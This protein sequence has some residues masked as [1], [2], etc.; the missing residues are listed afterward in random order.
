MVGQGS[1]TMQARGNEEVEDEK[2]GGREAGK[3]REPPADGEEDEGDFLLVAVPGIPRSYGLRTIQPF[4]VRS[5]S[6]A[7]EDFPCSDCHEDE[8][9]NAKERELTEEH[10]NKQ[11][12]HGGERFWCLTCHGSK[13][14]DSLTS[15]KGRPIGFDESFILCGQCHF[16]R[17][18]DWYFGAHGK[19]IG[20]WRGERRVMTCPECHDPHS[21]SIKPF[22]PSPPPLARKGLTRREPHAERHQPVWVE[23]ARA[24]EAR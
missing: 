8:P 9:V 23:A 4:M 3:T 10:E 22:K 2:N 1:K 17:Q 19:R 11:L 15:L 12:Q 7:L 18:R 21:P 14:K 20:N 5:R 16:Q 24:T 13:N 6:E